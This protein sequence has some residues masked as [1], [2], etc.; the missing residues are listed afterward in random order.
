[1]GDFLDSMMPYILHLCE[2]NLIE[3]ILL[4]INNCVWH[5]SKDLLKKSKSTKYLS[6]VIYLCVSK[7]G[8]H[9]LR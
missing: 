1:M 8:H 4:D 7:L 9:C 5:V 3:I 6:A 2:S